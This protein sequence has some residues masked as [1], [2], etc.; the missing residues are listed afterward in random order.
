MNNNFKVKE[1]T[2]SMSMLQSFRVNYISI[3]DNGFIK[4]NSYFFKEHIKIV[5]FK[6]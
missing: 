2:E 5:A 6:H 3:S 4:T 1:M